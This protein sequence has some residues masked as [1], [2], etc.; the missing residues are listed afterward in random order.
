MFSTEQILKIRKAH[1]PFYLYDLDLLRK[2]I[3]TASGEAKKAGYAIYYSLK[4]NN[5]Q[6][7]LKATLDKGFG[8]DCVS[9]NEIKRALKAGFKNDKIVFAGVGKTD[10]EI[11]TALK[12]DIDCFNCESVEEIEL[13]SRFAGQ[14]QKSAGISVRINPGISANTHRYLNTGNAFNKFGI[15]EISFSLVLSK[16]R[17]LPN[18]EIKGVHFHIGSQITDMDVFRSLC[19]KANDILHLL[20]LKGIR[21]KHVNMGG[22]LGIDYQNPDSNMIPDFKAYFAIF[23]KNLITYGNPEIRFELGRS[24]VGQCGNL[25]TRVLYVKNGGIKKFAVVDAGMTDLIRPALYN[26]K[27][28]IC[29]ISSIG[30][31]QTYDVVGPVCESSDFLGKDINIPETKRGDYLVIRSAGAYGQV[32]ASN[33]NLRDKAKAF[34]IE[35]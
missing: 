12:Y 13:I 11:I 29:N 3:D 14:L 16:I 33:Y 4:A 9:G 15:P 17:Q 30:P 31:S 26:S 19:I 21:L 28:L 23:K 25:V 27:H 6:P 8:A 7:I 5:N 2:T 22:G 35:N 18:I 10:E 1:T 34:Y 32:M 20:D 24:L